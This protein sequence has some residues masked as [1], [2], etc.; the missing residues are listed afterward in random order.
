MSEIYEEKFSSHN[1]TILQSIGCNS[2]HLV[3]KQS[4]KVLILL[5]FSFSFSEANLLFVESPYGVGFSYTNTSSDFQELGDEVTGK[6][7][8]NVI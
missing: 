3:E 4:S 6:A 8:C 5:R 7:I 1:F 2:C